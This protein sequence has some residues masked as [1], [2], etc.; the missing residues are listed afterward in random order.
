MKVYENKENCCGCGLCEKICPKQA[1]VLCED[2]NGFMYPSI[3]EKKCIEC[4]LCIKSCNFN[5]EGTNSVLESYAA[6]NINQKSIMKSASGGMFSA[7]ATDF[8]KHN[9]V[10][11]GVTNKFGKSEVKVEHQIVNKKIDL[12]KLQGSKYVQSDIR[13]IL[14]E[15]QKKLKNGEKV[16][17]SGTPCQVAA[18]KK[19]NEKCDDKLYTIDIICHGV[20]SNKVFNDYLKYQSQYGGFNI[21]DFIFRDKKYGWGLDGCIKAINKKN[22][23]I[24]KK[25]NPENSSYYHFF[26]TGE[27]Y[28][29]SCYQCPYAQESR[30]GDLTIGD[31][32]GIEQYSPEM[33]KKNGGKFEESNGVSCLLVNNYKG[34]KLLVDYGKNIEKMPVSIKK[35]KKINTQLEHPANYTKIRKILLNGYKNIGYRFIERKFMSWKIRYKLKIFLL[36]MIPKKIKQKL[37]NLKN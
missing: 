26:L 6:I 30:I 15:I 8:L 25:I 7:L 18:V 16:L 1:I 13:P 22:R 27:I 2:S 14:I 21:I 17:F 12:E 34:K 33:L 28:R 19:M 24:E 36:R 31:Y 4:G 11:V 32:W 23:V 35:I 20:P 3:N 5:A 29:E 37:K 10:V 9:G